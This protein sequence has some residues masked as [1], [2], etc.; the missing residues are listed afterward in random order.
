MQPQPELLLIALALSGVTLKTSDFLGERGSTPA[1]YISATISA[2][3]FGLLMSESTFSSSLI[4][5][6]IVGVTLSKKVDKP[7]MIFGL[8]LTIITAFYFGIKTPS[9]WLLVVVA[10]FAFIDEIGHDRLS[11]RSGVFALFFSYRLTLKLAMTTLTGL[12]LV[13]AVYYV[14]FLCFDLSYDLASHLLTRIK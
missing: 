13:E 3:I 1:S 4:L 14:G 11:Q 8:I 6:I 9:L 7:N 5:G 2:F 12:S 10:F